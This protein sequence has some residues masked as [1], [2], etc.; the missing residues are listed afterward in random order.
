MAETFV[1][2]LLNLVIVD[3]PTAMILSS[4]NVDTLNVTFTYSNEYA[5]FITF[6]RVKA[7]EVELKE[8][9]GEK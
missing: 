8:V 2:G 9:E 3:V 5:V 6:F 1:D 7:R 4:T